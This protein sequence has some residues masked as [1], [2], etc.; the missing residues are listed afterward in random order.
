MSAKLNILRDELKG[1]LSGIEATKDKQDDYYRRKHKG[2]HQTNTRKIQL[3]LNDLN[4]K[5]EKLIKLYIKTQG[6][7]KSG[8]DSFIFQKPLEDIF[9]EEERFTTTLIEYA[10][11]QLFGI[12]DLA[13]G[14]DKSKYEILDISKPETFLIKGE[15]GDV[16]ERE[17]EELRRLQS[18][19][20]KS[21]QNFINAE[22][23]CVKYK[24]AVEIA[25]KQLKRLK[26]LDHF[27]VTDK[28]FSEE[29]ENLYSEISV[30]Q[31]GLSNCYGSELLPLLGKLQSLNSTKVIQGDYNLK[32]LRQDYFVSKQNEV[33]K[34]LFV[35]FSRNYLLT[36]LYEI[37]FKTHTNLHHLLSTLQSLLSNEIN[38]IER[39]TVLSHKLVSGI[40]SEKQIISTNDVYM[41]HVYEAILCQTSEIPELYRSYNDLI[42]AVNGLSQSYKR[43][44]RELE[45]A[46][47]EKSQH[48]QLIESTLCEAEGI[49]RSTK[50]KSN[51][52]LSLVVINLEENL[53]MVE[54][55]VND[56]IKDIME[57]KTLL[58]VDRLEEIRRTIFADFFNDPARL[59]R[60]LQEL[61]SRVNNLTVS[62]S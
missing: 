50:D 34:Q 1:K 9:K 4:S 39:R 3:T 33:I 53:S 58:S 48:F 25:E 46:E 13:C 31:S 17:R 47:A 60:N 18:A 2:L 26:S 54:V 10:Q 27:D 51:E 52:E 29:I 42:A 21:K 19:Y 62:G 35:Q 57:K 20:L 45:S 6:S 41:N 43:T 56:I 61:V 16:K 49:I 7:E 40:K 23:S 5:V 37:E 38:N 24:K 32:L 14:E 8:G 22:M 28:Q 30:C 36:L 11:K 59:K 44:N 15:G 12:S 55:Q